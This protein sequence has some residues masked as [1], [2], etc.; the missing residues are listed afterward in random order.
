MAAEYRWPIVGGDTETVVFTFPE[1]VDLSG[2]WRCQVRTVHDVLV[3][4][5]SVAVDT[6][7][8]TVTV[9]MTS[10]QSAECEAA[11]ARLRFGLRQ[12]GEGGAPVAT[13]FVGDVVVSSGVAELTD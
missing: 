7:A 3:T 12:I 2:T 9:T 4:S 5:P 11:G 13:L 1:A 6:D 10:A 8:N